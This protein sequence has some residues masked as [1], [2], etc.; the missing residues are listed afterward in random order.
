MIVAAVASG[1]AAGSDPN[2]TRSASISTSPLRYV[3]FSRSTVQ[4]W[5]QFPSDLLRAT[6][7]VSPCIP[8]NAPV[9]LN[10]GNPLIDKG[11]CFIAMMTSRTIC[12]AM[13]PLEPERHSIHLLPAIL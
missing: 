7:R 1:R 4:D 12:N 10:R 5:R 8:L 11:L 2:R 6:L 9:I 3:R 13:R